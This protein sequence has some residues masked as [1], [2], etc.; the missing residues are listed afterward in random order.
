MLETTEHKVVS[1]DNLVKIA[2][3]VLED[4][5]FEFN[6]GVKKQISGKVIGT[7]FAPPYVCIIT[8]DLEKTFSEFQSLQSLVWFK[9]ID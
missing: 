5:Y 6:S 9:Y 3:F 2:H 8:D 1:T 7:K 4:N